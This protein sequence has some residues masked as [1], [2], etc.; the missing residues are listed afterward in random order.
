MLK[1][2]LAIVAIGLV[3]MPDTLAQETPA[4][5][6]VVR[7]GTALKVSTLQPLDSAAARPGDDV[8]LRLSRPLV[9]NG[10]TL[11]REGELLH[12][13]VTHV[14]R[15]GPRC[16]YG[17]V[18]WKIDRISFAD[19]TNARSRLYTDGPWRR[20]VPDQL[21]LGRDRNAFQRFVAPV[22]GAPILGLEFIVVSP[23]LFLHDDRNDGCGGGQEYLLPTNSLVVVVI[24]KDHH[25]RF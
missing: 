3:V 22:L 10:V 12:G 13:R 15:A 11:L 9:V 25:V 16:R 21:P 20:P 18:H 2:V 23:R 8:P 1:Q 19:K 14:Q 5:K 6:T 4:Q 7:R 17:Q 24:T